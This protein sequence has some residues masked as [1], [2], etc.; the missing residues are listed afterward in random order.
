ML[1]FFFQNA[2]VAAI[3]PKP[4]QLMPR[5]LI[6]QQIYFYV[7]VAELDPPLSCPPV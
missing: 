6:P 4:T 2:F 5:K 7:R 3:A 1:T